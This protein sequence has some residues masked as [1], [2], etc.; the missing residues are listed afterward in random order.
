MATN[1]R[2]IYFHTDENA[3][4]EQIYSLFDDVESAGKDDIDNLIDSSDT[5]FID[6]DYTSS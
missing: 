5:E 1:S 6:E 4:T 3:S 2:K